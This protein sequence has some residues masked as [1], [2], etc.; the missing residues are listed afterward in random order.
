MSAATLEEEGRAS[1]MRARE[2]MLAVLAYI[3]AGWMKMI[4]GED[5]RANGSSSASGQT[6]QQTG[7]GKSGVA[8]LKSARPNHSTR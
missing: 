4:V 2:E 3:G 8:S 7:P 5:A 1:T 6:A